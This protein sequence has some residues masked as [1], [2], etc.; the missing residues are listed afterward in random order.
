M[1]KPLRQPYSQFFGTLANQV[2]LDILELLRK[3][4]KNVGE[5][6][7]ELGYEQSTISHSLKRLVECGFVSVQPEGKVRVYSL[8]AKTIGPILDLMNEHMGTYC[9]HVVAKKE[10][11][12]NETKN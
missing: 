11:L 2:R 3:G 10:K 1:R 12:K 9:C 4:P 5:L 8:Y 6:T 7:S